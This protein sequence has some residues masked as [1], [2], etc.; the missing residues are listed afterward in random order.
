MTEKE[1]IGRDITRTI[2]AVLFIAI[3]IA[4]SFW[5]LRPF[6]TSIV[7]AAIIVVAT[8]PVLLKV[9]AAFRGRRGFA[10]AVMTVVLLM[11]IF[12]PL[13]IGIMAIAG[14]S[15]DIASRIKT[16]SAFTIPPPPEWVSNIPLGGRKLAERW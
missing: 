1:S 2:L 11:V 9:Q 6:L 8:W 10:V 3:L 16:L 15:E 12:V 13:I 7:W 5:I 4:V 14:K